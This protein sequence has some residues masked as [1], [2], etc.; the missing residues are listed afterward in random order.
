MTPYT[1]Y[2]IQNT[3]YI[4]ITLRKGGEFISQDPADLKSDPLYVKVYSLLKGWIMEGR[5]SPG[6]RIRETVLAAELRVSRT[7]VRDALRRLEQDRLIVAEPGSVYVVYRPT[8]LD[9]DDLYMARAVLEGGAARLAAQR[10]PT[11]P[12][13]HMTAIL[14]QMA[15]A[16][17][18][19]SLA[20]LRELDAQFHEWLIAA[21][22]NAVLVELANHLSTRLRHIRTLSGDIAVRQQLV[23][24]QHRAIVDAIRDGNPD[25]AES[26]TRTHVLAIHE[27]VRTAFPPR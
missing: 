15:D 19:S 5:L 25:L 6:E 20:H 21:S 9:L 16:Y 11:G 14:A 7:P 8:A 12:M 17:G 23:L 24:E 10:S 4:F 3:K 2:G 13:S 26:A 1:E 18:Q 22:G 27:A